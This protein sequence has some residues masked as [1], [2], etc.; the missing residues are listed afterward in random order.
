MALSQEEN[1]ARNGT[2]TTIFG[3]SVSYDATAIK[4]GGVAEWLSVVNLVRSSVLGS[5]PTVGTI[6]PQANSQLSCPSYRD[7]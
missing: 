7:R 2:E 4:H 6:L 5:C 1:E 3:H